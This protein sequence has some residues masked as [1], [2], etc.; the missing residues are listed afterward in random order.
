MSSTKQMLSALETAPFPVILCS[1]SQIR[2]EPNICRYRGSVRLCPVSTACALFWGCSP[3][4]SGWRGRFMRRRS[5]IECGRSG[6]THCRRTVKG[7]ARERS[8]Q[9]MCRYAHPAGTAPPVL[10]R[11]HR[12]P[13]CSAGSSTLAPRPASAHFQNQVKLFGAWSCCIRAVLLRMRAGNEVRC[14]LTELGTISSVHRPAVHHPLKCQSLTQSM[15]A[16]CQTRCAACRSQ[17][18]VDLQ[19]QVGRKRLT[20][21][22]E[23]SSASSVASSSQAPF[24]CCACKHAHL[25]DVRRGTGQEGKHGMMEDLGGPPHRG[26]P[27]CRA[28]PPSRRPCRGRAAASPPGCRRWRCSAAAPAW[29]RPPGACRAGC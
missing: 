13:S 5:P 29:M 19:C 2:P 26:A 23:E 10:R 22:S 9:L 28:T 18:R 27:R 21:S 7:G 6:G 1:G 16:A 11:C 17:A 8:E 20:S 24:C 4:G 25:E 14:S 15:L 3:M 12:P